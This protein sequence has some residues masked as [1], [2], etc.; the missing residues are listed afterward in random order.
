MAVLNRE[1][2]LSRIKER[3]GDSTDD[4]TIR[5]VTDMT[6]T[7]DEFSNNE[8]KEKY[9]DLTTVHEALRREYLDRFFS[10]AS[11][12]D[13]EAAEPDSGDISFEDILK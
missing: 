4:E 2:F 12:E 7:Y 13:D 5:F 1:D 11:D 3:I 6:D 10:G 9:D 8:W